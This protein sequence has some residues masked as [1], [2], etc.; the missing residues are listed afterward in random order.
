MKHLELDKIL[1][2]Y[3]LH[4]GAIIAILSGRGWGK[5]EQ[6]KVK[7]LEDFENGLG[8]FEWVI[9]SDEMYKDERDKFFDGLRERW[10]NGEKFKF[11]PHDYTVD[12]NK[13]YKINKEYLGTDEKGNEKWKETKVIAGFM[14]LLV[15]LK[16]KG[17]R[18]KIANF[19]YDEFND[20]IPPIH[21]N[22]QFK[23]WWKR[24]I[25]LTTGE[26]SP[27][28]WLLGNNENHNTE[29][30]IRIGISK[31]EDGITYE[32]G[33][34]LAIK[35]GRDMSELFGGQDA[36]V[37]KLAKRFGVYEST[38]STEYAGIERLNIINFKD[39]SKFTPVLSFSSSNKDEQS[40]IVTIYSGY[41]GEEFIYY[42]VSEWSRDVYNDESR[43]ESWINKNVLAISA[44]KGHENFRVMNKKVKET[45]KNEMR[46]ISNNGKMYFKYERCREL[47][48]EEMFK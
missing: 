45:F 16:N 14:K 31:L 43:G 24:I 21:K 38:F 39:L 13:I 6:A 36:A 27:R 32:D 30:S 47:F 2:K 10:E 11:N 26:N 7:C 8:K 33:L 5:T 41:L 34:I 46:K 22:F 40:F 23:W 1:K 28:I 18:T 17:S 19:V 15:H 42:A 20:G 37:V 35:D 12:G 4:P 3:P 48:N 9:N 25:T 44:N 29:I